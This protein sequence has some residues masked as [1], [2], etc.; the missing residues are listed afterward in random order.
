MLFTIVAVS[1]AAP[2]AHAEPSIAVPNVEGTSTKTIR[3]QLRKIVKDEAKLVS[4]KRTMRYFKKAKYKKSPGKALAKLKADAVVFAELKPVRRKIR[5]KKRKRYRL[6][7]K[8]F[9]A[10][11]ERV[12]KFKLYLRQRSLRT[13]E[14]RAVAKRLRKVFAE[15]EGEDEGDIDDGD[16]D[17]GDGDGDG[18]DDGDGGGGGD[19]D[20][21]GD[22]DDKG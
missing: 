22:G 17:D 13:K 8:V 11:G 7:I 12:D 16:D 6:R 5:G 10:D 19:G 3:R 4:Y 21:S 18:D 20:D 9:G 1:V 14:R 15:L 2:R